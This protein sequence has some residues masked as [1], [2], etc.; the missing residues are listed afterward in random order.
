MSRRL[1]TVSNDQIDEIYSLVDR[2]G[3][4]AYRDAKAAAG[5]NRMAPFHRAYRLEAQ[6]V[7]DILKEKCLR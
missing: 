3:V 2:L 6:T 5:I 1:L 4:G 7:I